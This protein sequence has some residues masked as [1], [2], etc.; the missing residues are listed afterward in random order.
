MIMKQIITILFLGFL[1]CIVNAQ[2]STE[3]IPYSWLR[4]NGKTINSY[5]NIALS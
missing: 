2:I 5:G 4:G 3:E 1:C